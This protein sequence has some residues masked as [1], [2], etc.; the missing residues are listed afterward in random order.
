MGN[1]VNLD[2]MTYPRCE[3]AK[4]E[5][6]D[7]NLIIGSSR[8]CEFGFYD[9]TQDVNLDEDVKLEVRDVNLDFHIPNSHPCPFCVQIHIFPVCSVTILRF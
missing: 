3:F 5:R 8:R 9:L 1:D 7:V 6:Q 4:V 2:F